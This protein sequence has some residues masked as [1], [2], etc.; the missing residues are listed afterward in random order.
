MTFQIRLK[1]KV[2]VALVMVFAIT[3]E[4]VIAEATDTPI[5]MM[6]SKNV[7]V[8]KMEQIEVLEE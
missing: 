1:R 4:N 8:V 5:N 7:E 2:A 3:S 6:F